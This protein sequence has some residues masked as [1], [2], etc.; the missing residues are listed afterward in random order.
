MLVDKLIKYFLQEFFV[1]HQNEDIFHMFQDLI[2]FVEQ[3]DSNNKSQM[4][5]FE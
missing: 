3:M 5:S 1:I 2:D 4:K